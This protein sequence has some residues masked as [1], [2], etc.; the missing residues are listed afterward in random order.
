MTIPPSHP[1]LPRERLW[2]LG[3]AALTVQELVAILLGTGDAHRDALGVAGQLL[4][5]G[6]GAL[7]RLVARPPAELLRTPGVGPAKGARLLAA[8]ELGQRL[9]REG[10]PN[11]LRIREPTDVVRLVGVAS[12][13]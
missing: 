5:A 7:R 11:V 4:E 3:V 8:L 2:R 9:A 12:G 6:D 10:R 13:T 1:D